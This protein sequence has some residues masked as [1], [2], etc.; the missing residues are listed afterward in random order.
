MKRFIHHPSSCILFSSALLLAGCGSP[1]G[2]SQ[3]IDPNG[4]RMIVD[5]GRINF[6][7][8]N[9][10]ASDL[11][12]AML[13]ANAIKDKHPGSPT[14][15]LVSTI[16]N[17]TDQQF[18]TDQLTANIR[19]SLLQTGRIQIIAS[20]AS[21]AVP[22]YILAG[23]IMMDKTYAGNINQSAYSFDIALTDATTSA[24]VWENNHQV[25]KQGKGSS[26]G[27]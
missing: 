24:I 21:G 11:V 9:T 22:D 4:Q 14:L 1:P 16:T 20:A 5:T 25:V 12:Q 6:Q 23:K 26:V 8:F 19:S 17:E 27:L 13:N 15:V 2:N 3:Y 10:T 7:D 18:D